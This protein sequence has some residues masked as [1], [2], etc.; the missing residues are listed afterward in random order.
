LS[1]GDADLLEKPVDVIGFVYHDERLDADSF[2]VVRYVIT[3]CSA[4]GA[5]AGL[6]VVWENGGALPVDSWVRVQGKIGALPIAGAEQAAIIASAVEPVTQ[7]DILTSI[8][9]K[10]S[11]KP[12]V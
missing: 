3:C 6:P 4:D 2:Y 11:E 9:K 1:I 10:L 5:G 12:F 8:P 7:P